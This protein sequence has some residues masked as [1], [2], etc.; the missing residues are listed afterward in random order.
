MSIRTRTRRLHLENL[1]GRALM[2][3]SVSVA[4]GWLVIT[5][6]NGQNDQAVVT[7]TNPAFA[8]SQVLVSF[9]GQ[10]SAFAKPL[11]TQG[12]KVD[13]PEIAS[14]PVPPSDMEPLIVSVDAKGN[15]YLDFGEDRDAPVAPET[16]VT[17]VGAVLRYRPGVPVLVNGDRGV[18]YARVLELMAL[19][20]GAGVK[21]VGL[22][23]VPPQ[24]K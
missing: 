24:N 16:L 12:V 2:A 15:F 19:L 22:M 6:A 23:T 3:G 10:L 5:G 9:N 13:L 7:D 11:I 21:G 4:A 14:Q 17:R 8:G 18:S 1:E 20:Q